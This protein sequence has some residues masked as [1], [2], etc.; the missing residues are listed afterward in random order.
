MEFLSVVVD[1]VDGICHLLEQKAMLLVQH[2]SGDFFI[3]IVFVCWVGLA[4]CSEV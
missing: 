4:S 1:D 2:V 3:L